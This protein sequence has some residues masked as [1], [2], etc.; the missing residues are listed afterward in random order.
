MIIVDSF[1]TYELLSDSCKVLLFPTS[2]FVGKP[3]SKF[4][5]RYACNVNF[6]SCM[7]P[8]RDYYNERDAHWSVVL[9]NHWEGPKLTI[10]N[11]TIIEIAYSTLNIKSL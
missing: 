1:A 6:D 4:V 5:N 3:V 11:D 10:L 2:E 8:I 7:M 9:S